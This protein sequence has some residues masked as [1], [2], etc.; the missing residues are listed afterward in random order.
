[1]SHQVRERLGAP[2]VDRNHWFP[3]KYIA[4]RDLVAEQDYLITRHRVHNRL[5]H[6]CGVLCGL[7]VTAHPRA[8]CVQRWIVVRAGIALDPLGRELILMADRPVRLPAARGEDRDFVVCL[9]YREDR[10]EEV[11]ILYADP[12]AGLPNSDANRIREG[13]EIVAVPAARFDPRAWDACD[14]GCIEAAPDCGELV[15]L[16]VAEV[17]AGGGPVT[18]HNRA[19]R[20]GLPS[21]RPACIIEL[22][23]E[24][25]GALSLEEIERVRR[26]TVRFDRPLARAQGRARGICEDTFSVT[27]SRGHEA[28][29]PLPFARAPG[30]AEDD[31]VAVFEIAKRA[32]HEDDE[33]HL[34]NAT[35]H[36][37]LRCDFILDRHGVAVSGRHI[38][39]HLPSGDGNPGG[40]FESWF[41]VSHHAASQPATK[42]DREAGRGQEKEET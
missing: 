34:A 21:H 26:L 32:F 40:T 27:Y 42:G 39:G 9:R 28:L 33:T 38:G 23:W 15:A 16:A 1:M 2:A 10:V 3:Y 5:L 29:R 22:S 12:D 20:I 4:A 7:G 41:R 19:R 31:H 37:T 13:V 6:G 17:D 14:P 36:V 24:H 30:L 18:I 35:V 8:D 11:P 25:G